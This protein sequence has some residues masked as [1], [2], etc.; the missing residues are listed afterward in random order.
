MNLNKNDK[1]SGKT[2]CIKL[3][4]AQYRDLKDSADFME[5]S[6]SQEARL[7]LGHSLSKFKR[8]IN[9]NEVTSYSEEV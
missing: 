8:V 4:H 9:E 2:I 7:R 5:R 1:T 6:L 3:T